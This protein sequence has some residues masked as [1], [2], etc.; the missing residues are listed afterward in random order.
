M[1]WIISS[2]PKYYRTVEAFTHLKVVDWGQKANYKVGD[3]VFIYSTR[4]IQMIEVW[5]KV[6][7]INKYI[8]DHKDLAYWNVA[9]KEINPKE[10]YVELELIQINS[11]YRLDLKSLMDEGLNGAPQRPTRLKEKTIRYIVKVFKN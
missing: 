8:F 7:R 11:D 5:A 10:L 1:N 2:N 6:I 9:P 4:P 3:N